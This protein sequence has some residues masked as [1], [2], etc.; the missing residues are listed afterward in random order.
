M[1]KTTDNRAL[2]RA[3][4]LYVDLAGPMESK[5]AGGSRYV[6]TIVDYFNCFKVSKFLKTKSTAETAAAL[7]SYISTYITPGKVS[8]RAVRTTH[9][10]EFGGEFQ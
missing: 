9:G 2:E 8:I 10:G 4:L 7:E 3:A 5:S 1:P 6:T